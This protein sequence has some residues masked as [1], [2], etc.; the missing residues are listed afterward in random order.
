MNK[1]YQANRVLFWLATCIIAGIVWA[2]F[3]SSLW[4]G[5]IYAGVLFALAVIYE[6]FFHK[7]NRT[8]K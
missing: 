5:A 4:G 8:K 2:I 1:L 6:A 7:E 3:Q